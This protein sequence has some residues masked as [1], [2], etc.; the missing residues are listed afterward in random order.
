MSTVRV[1]SKGQI[2]LPAAVRHRL[3]LSTGAS[4]QLVELSDGLNLTVLRAVPK[5]DLSSLAGMIKVRASGKK[6]SLDD[7]D[8]AA[9]LAKPLL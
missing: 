5:V 1:S 3:G 7:F 4:L 6:R 9:M 2:V 8:A